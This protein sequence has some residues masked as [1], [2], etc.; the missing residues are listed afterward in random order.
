MAT[1]PPT[2]RR[3]CC[4]LVVPWQP[5]GY[6]NKTGVTADPV[7]FRQ[8]Q[9]QREEY[10]F[11]VAGWKNSLKIHGWFGY[12]WYKSSN[13]RTIW[14]MY[15]IIISG[16]TIWKNRISSHG[17]SWVFTPF[18]RAPTLESSRVPHHLV[19]T[20]GGEKPAGGISRD[21]W[22]TKLWEAW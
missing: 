1:K 17:F 18:P 16:D 21:P 15:N 7:C 3:F 8:E 12:K 4:T 5:V 19:D 2:S 13:S 14:K 9:A 10:S 11:F 6:G 22:M 20:E